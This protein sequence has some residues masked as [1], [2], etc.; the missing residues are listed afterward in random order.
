MR[1]CVCVRVF[2]RGER[3]GGRNILKVK[4]KTN[5][6]VCSVCVRAKE[7]GKEGG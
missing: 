5:C 4:E 3:G 2:V 6:R 1:V 7:K